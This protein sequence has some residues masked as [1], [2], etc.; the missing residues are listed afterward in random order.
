MIINFNIFYE[1][2]KN[3]LTYKY[4][5]PRLS[6]YSQDNIAGGI[7]SLI[8]REMN[9]V[10][11]MTTFTR[12]P[13]LIWRALSRLYMCFLSSVFNCCLFIFS[14]LQFLRHPYLNVLFPLKW[15]W[16]LQKNLFGW[17]GYT[18][19]HY[20]QKMGRNFVEKSFMSIGYGGLPLHPMASLTL[21]G[22]SLLS[23]GV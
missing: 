22:K 23:V 14:I 5:I 6:H 11:S 20:H 8:T 13:S 19:L 9:Q 1:S 15:V 16:L 4:I 3:Q 7:P 10:S 18:G 21:I 2:I 12:P 17:L